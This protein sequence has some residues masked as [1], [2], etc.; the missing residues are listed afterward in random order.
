[1]TKTEISKEEF[2]KLMSQDMKEKDLEALFNLYDY[3][4]NGNFLKLF[5]SSP[6]EVQSVGGSMSV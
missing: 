1:M 4:H 5:F 6:N 2:K 3:D